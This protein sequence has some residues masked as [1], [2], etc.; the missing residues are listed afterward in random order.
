[1]KVQLHAMLTS[2]LYASGVLHAPAALL[3]EEADRIGP[4]SE[5]KSRMSAPYWNWAVVPR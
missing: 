2:A 5:E 1:M 3:L 4:R